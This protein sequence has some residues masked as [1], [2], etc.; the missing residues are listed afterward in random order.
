[1]KSLYLNFKNKA[2]LGESGIQLLAFIISYIFLK[3]NNFPEKVFF[4]EEIFIIMSIPGLDM[5]R[6]F[7]IRI[8][9][10]QNPFKADNNHLHHLFLRKFKYSQ[11]F[12]LIQFLI[13]APIIFF[14]LQG[15]SVISVI[16]AIIIYLLSFLFLKLK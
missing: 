4:A 16:V 3:T 10:G 5:F 12:L 2:Y 6:L 1:M 7:C 9:K 15:S 14:L 8:L 11:S 13:I